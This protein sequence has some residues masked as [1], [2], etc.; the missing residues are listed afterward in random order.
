RLI[1]ALRAAETER[2]GGQKGTGLGGRNFC[3]PSLSDSDFSAAAEFRISLCEM[4][5]Q[6]ICLIVFIKFGII[7]LKV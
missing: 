1:A 3:P 5:R 7:I 6:R 4:R 2:S